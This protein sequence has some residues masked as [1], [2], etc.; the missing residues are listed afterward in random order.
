MLHSVLRLSNSKPSVVAT[1]NKNKNKN[2]SNHYFVVGLLCDVVLN[3]GPVVGRRR[4]KK[5][6]VARSVL[7]VLKLQER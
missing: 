7:L 4:R 5:M 6:V 3:D 2:T 1:D